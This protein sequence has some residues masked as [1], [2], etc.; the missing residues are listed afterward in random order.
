MGDNLRTLFSCNGRRRWRARSLAAVK[1]VVEHLAEACAPGRGLGVDISG[2]GGG[3]NSRRFPAGLSLTTAVELREKKMLTSRGSVSVG[4]ASLLAEACAAMHVHLLQWLAVVTSAG[5]DADGRRGAADASGGSV[6][7][8]FARRLL[9]DLLFLL[10][11]QLLPAI[12]GSRRAGAGRDATYLVPALL[13][14]VS[15]DPLTEL[16]SAVMDTLDGTIGKSTVMQVQFMSPP[17]TGKIST[18][19][20]MA[21]AVGPVLR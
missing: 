1:D 8:D 17:V 15:R 9:V 21:L 14:E 4:S 20:L 11:K 18:Q 19:I 16:L 7:L 12:G 13:A 2:S 5:E 6:L 3:A 10:E